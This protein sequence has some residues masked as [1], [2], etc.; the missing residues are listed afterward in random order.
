M[1]VELPV[2]S[3]IAR[4]RDLLGTPF[5]LHGRT[6]EEGLDCVGF[7][8]LVFGQGA[9]VPTGY[10]MRNMQGERWATLLDGLATRRGGGGM[11][12]ADILLLQAG[13]AQYHLGLWTGDSLI[14]ADARLR[15]V[16]EV[17]GA[18]AWPVLG[19]WCFSSRFAE[20]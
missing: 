18:L 6:L 17:P 20:T 14:H 10:A 1:S 2:D 8:A 3:I 5:K 11:R 16:V 9:D 13:P 15:R 12:P 19:A 4:A 7:V